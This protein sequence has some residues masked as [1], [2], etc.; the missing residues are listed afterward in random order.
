MN[1]ARIAL[2]VW[3]TLLTVA[4]P[5]LADW[6]NLPPGPEAR[7]VYV[8]ASEVEGPRSYACLQGFA[9][10]IGG[11]IVHAVTARRRAT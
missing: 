11:F 3:A 7:I 8:S 9:L 5:V 1:A 4:V 10:A 2:G 6:T